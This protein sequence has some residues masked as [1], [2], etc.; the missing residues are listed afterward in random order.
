MFT[1]DW[2]KG[3]AE[4]AIRTFLQVIVGAFTA[5]ATVMTIDWAYAIVAAA[6]ATLLSL[7]M[8]VLATGVGNAGPS[9]G[10]ETLT[11]NVAAKN[12]A[13]GDT[14][15]VAGPAADAPDGA[16]VYV[17]EKDDAGGEG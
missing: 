5:G 17:I 4:R 13:E 16:P 9:F 3:A 8:S 11:H 7:I 1:T 12:A 10:A 6:T 2:L 15:F 14:G